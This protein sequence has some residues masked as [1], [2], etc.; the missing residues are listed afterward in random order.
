MVDG[1][2]SGYDRWWLDDRTVYEE[3]GWLDG[4]QTGVSRRWTDGKLDSG[5]PKFFVRG[6]RVSKREYVAAASA[7]RRI[8]EYR[9]KDDSPE[10]TLPEQFIELRRRVRRL[11]IA[12]GKKRPSR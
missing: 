7:D 12:A 9:R 5:S 1:R 6:E 3:T 10:R 8:P 4:Q 11:G 2:I